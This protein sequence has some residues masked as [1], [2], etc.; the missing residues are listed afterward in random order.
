MRLVV[1]SS[2]TKSQSLNTIADDQ[3]M[4]LFYAYFK[5]SGRPGT[6]KFHGLRN[7]SSI[8]QANVLSIMPADAGQVTFS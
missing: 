6:I 7:D 8:M 3:E 1:K 5:H 4:C 2:R